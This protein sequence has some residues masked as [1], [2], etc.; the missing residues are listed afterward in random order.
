MMCFNFN[1]V[2][3]RQ[4]SA[5]DK[6]SG[7]KQRVT[8]TSDKGRLSEADIERMVQEAEDNAE[9][10]LALREAVDAKN[11]L[12]SYLYGVKSSINDSLKDKLAEKDRTKIVNV[13][14]DAFK[15][16]EEHVSENKEAYEGKRKEVEAVASP[17]ISKAY[18]SS[19]N[20]GAAG[21]ES[22]ETTSSADAAADG[23][24]S[25]DDPSDPTIEEVE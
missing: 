16:L 4:V 3:L 20:G 10:D 1:F 12:E 14:E 21:A 19:P 25:L 23:G 2:F 17:I 9:A 15:W 7:K 8:I 6:A 13:V 18:T 22:E 11:M 24:E 5:E